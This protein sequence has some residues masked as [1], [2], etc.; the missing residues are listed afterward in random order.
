MCDIIYSIEDNKNS[1]C[2]EIYNGILL[3][4]SQNAMSIILS[5]MNQLDL[6]FK[7]AKRDMKEL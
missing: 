1:I 5:N 2:K 3:K 7:T 4:G 6:R